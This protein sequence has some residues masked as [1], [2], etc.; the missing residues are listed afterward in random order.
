MV[1]PLGLLA[2]GAR[3]ARGG[4]D[5]LAP[6]GAVQRRARHRDRDAP[7]PLRAAPAA[8]DALPQPVAVRASCSRAPPPTCPRSAGSAASGC[9][10][11]SSTSCSSWSSR[12]CC[13]TCTGRSAWSSPPPPR[14]SCGSRC[15]SRRRY[16]VV[17]RRVQDEQGDLATLSEE[18][19][20][21]IRVIKSFGRSE[22]VVA[23]VRGTAARAL[24]HQHGQ[25]PAVR[26]V[27]DLPRGASPTSP[28]SWC[29]CSAR[30]ASARAADPRRA[31]RLHH[32]D[33]LAGLAGR[34]ARRDPRDGAGGDDRGRPD[35]GDLRHRARHRRRATG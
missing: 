9:C 29:C 8:A 12:S 31:G 4:A 21:G 23:A 15:A 34:L 28:S 5:L 19:A 30:S 20:V 24:R 18:G 2:L 6:L 1:L 25:G 35:P 22:H 33:A 17:S 14:R 10:S 7:R 11:W 26:E 16:V 32:P 3:R 27:L 13:W